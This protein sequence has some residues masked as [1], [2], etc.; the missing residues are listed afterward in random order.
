MNSPNPQ[1]I[2]KAGPDDFEDL[3]SSATAI[4]TEGA[5]QPVSVDKVT[6]LV[7]RCIQLDRA[8]AGIIVGD[9]GIEASIGMVIDTFPYS[10]A[11]HLSVVW[12]GVH[13]TFR[14]DHRGAQLMEF[15]NW[16]QSVMD[17]PLY[18]DLSTIEELQAKLHLY[19]RLAPQVA[20]KFAFGA[21]PEGQYNQRRVG[22]DPHQAQI[23]A[24]KVIRRGYIRRHTSPPAAA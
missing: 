22:D 17:V 23:D 19:L 7:G 3:I 5:L 15:A 1:G 13:P 8:I 14:G 18:V 9:A 4:L 2:R 10:E 24:L 20:A 6:A 12:L 21:V 16:A 11:E